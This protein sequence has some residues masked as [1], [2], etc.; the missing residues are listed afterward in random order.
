MIKS[1]QH[2]KDKG[3]E[4]RIEMFLELKTYNEMIKIEKHSETLP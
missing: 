1:E 2:R 4:R 3:Y